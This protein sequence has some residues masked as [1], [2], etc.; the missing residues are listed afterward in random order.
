VNAF[1]HA[2]GWSRAETLEFRIAG[3]VAEI[4]A[5]TEAVYTLVQDRLLVHGPYR[6]VGKGAFIDNSGF[7]TRKC[8]HSKY[9][10]VS[11]HFTPNLINYAFRIL[12]QF[13]CT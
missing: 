11:T 7:K 4:G 3:H 2:S 12:R 8:E 9:V 13:K 5:V 6:P 10:T 1:L